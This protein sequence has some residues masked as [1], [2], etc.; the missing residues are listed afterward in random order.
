MLF[1]ATMSG[2]EAILDL[3]KVKE[4]NLKTKEDLHV[5]YEAKDLLRARN[6]ENIKVGQK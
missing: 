2:F 4:S 6:P 5:S 3:E 1:K